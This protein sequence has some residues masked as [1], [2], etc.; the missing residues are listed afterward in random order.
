MKVTLVANLFLYFT[1]GIASAVYAGNDPV[2][3]DPH[4]TIIGSKGTGK[5]TLGNVL[6]GFEPD[7]VDCPFPSVANTSYGIGKG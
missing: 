4:L 1:L 6:L 3:P 5:S 2:L 7:C